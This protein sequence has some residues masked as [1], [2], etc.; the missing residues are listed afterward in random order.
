MAGVI[1]SGDRAARE[2]SKR[3]FGTYAT[4]TLLATP[5]STKC[6]DGALAIVTADHSVW[7]YDADATNTASA[8]VLVPSNSPTSGRWIRQTS[9]FDRV[10][11]ATASALPANTRT[12]NVLLA[13]A[14]GA[15]SGASLDGV[16]PVAGDLVLVKDESTGAN[17]GVYVIDSLGGASAQWQMT[18]APG[19]DV[20]A[21][22]TPNRTVAVS[23]GTANADTVW[24]LTTDAPITLNTTALTFTAISV[25]A[26]SIGTADIADDAVTAAK[27]ADSADTDGSRAVTRNHIRND[28]ID[29]TKIADDA[30]DSEH[31]ADGAIDLAHMSANS[32]DSDQYVDG[33]IDTAHYADASITAAKLANGAGLAALITAG[34]GNSI[35]VD[36]ADA[37]PTILAADAV[38]ARACLVVAVV[39]ETLAGAA[40][41]VVESVGGTALLTISAGT[42]GDV[43]V[44]AGIVTAH[45]TNSAIRVNATAGD[46][47]AVAVTIL[48]L[49]TA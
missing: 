37:D 30:V 9:V 4:T 21:A 7:E 35:N 39:T 25:T 3:F 45:E 32:I 22:V 8:N 19:W 13:D 14:N 48:A 15:L 26:G 24:M 18:R 49:P 10:R 46:T 20:S 2:A 36:N 47:G 29:G 23:E 34:L 6:V 5:Y 1:R 28:A 16:T 40:A 17:R 41:F 44:G 31:I 43:L 42:A 27:L 12:G 33:S 38:N 11:F